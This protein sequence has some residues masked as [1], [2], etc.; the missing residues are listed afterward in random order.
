MM[1][2]G[3]N[4]ILEWNPNIT[5]SIQCIALLRASN[6]TLA[7]GRPTRCRRMIGEKLHTVIP[8]G[9]ETHQSRRRCGTVGGTLQN[10]SM[11]KAEKAHEMMGV[12]RRKTKTEVNAS[13]GLIQIMR[14]HKGGGAEEQNGWNKVGIH[15]L[16]D[17]DNKVVSPRQTSIYVM[18]PWDHDNNI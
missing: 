8:K 17:P 2:N 16:L 9:E 10:M 1:K 3:S 4:P 6:S 11:D 13:S 5:A 18:C 14:F 12:G 15:V 7:S